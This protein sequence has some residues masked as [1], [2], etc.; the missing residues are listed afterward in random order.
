MIWTLGC[1]T[2]YFGTETDL[3]NQYS[4]VIRPILEENKNKSFYLSIIA[5]NAHD[6]IKFVKK[7][8]QETSLVDIAQPLWLLSQGETNGKPDLGSSKFVSVALYA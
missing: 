5:L 7:T 2:W 3:S 8:C 4:L 1:V 6:Q